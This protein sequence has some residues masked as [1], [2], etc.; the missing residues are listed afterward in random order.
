MHCISSL[1]SHH[2]VS[3][4]HFHY[5]SI[6]SQ[7]SLLEQWDL[8]FLFNSTSL[9]TVH[10]IQRHENKPVMP[11]ALPL[12]PITNAT[13]ARSKPLP[14]LPTTERRNV[15][16]RPTCTHLTM[17]KLFGA[18]EPCHMCNRIPTIGF[19]YA[20][21]QDSR[22]QHDTEMP[23][24]PK[25]P[26]MMTK[27]KN[28]RAPN[29]LE[30][31]GFSESVIKA[32]AAGHYTKQQLQKLKA[33]KKA[34]A[35][36]IV[37]ALQDNED[38]KARQGAPPV[39]LAEKLAALEVKTEPDE[40]NQTLYKE[41]SRRHRA[42]KSSFSKAIQ[43]CE[44]KVCHT[45]RPFS[46]DRTFVSFEAVFANEV[47]MPGAW[48][49]EYMPVADAG[50]LR[51]MNYI[52][53]MTDS[54]E[55]EVDYHNELG[56]TTPDSGIDGMINSLNHGFKTPDS[57][58]SSSGSS[59]YGFRMSWQK[60]LQDLLG[61]QHGIVPRDSTTSFNVDLWKS[62]SNEELAKAAAIKLPESRSDDDTETTEEVDSYIQGVDA[63]RGLET[64]HEVDEED[65]SVMITSV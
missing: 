46:R 16:P 32:A 53:D 24:S 5:S 10:L 15:N 45:C 44:F 2:L 58:V 37:Q 14:L 9:V 30:L 40:K 21:Q 64:M 42:R 61:K 3:S 4:V 13:A 17:D 63:R 18:D 43:P 55:E 60:N 59:T 33:Q 20:C 28:R 65:S 29:E 27:I 8:S 23:R 31:L 12:L 41:S 49:P 52:S 19:I 6:H 22:H 62:L 39:L 36:I 54:S 35:D 11:R 34:V 56:I 7:R 25:S 50:I 57:M 38:L 51:R 26:K 1:F 48:S 47:T